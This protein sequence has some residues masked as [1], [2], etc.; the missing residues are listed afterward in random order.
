M[1]SYADEE[2]RA[3]IVCDNGSGM[4][5]AGFAGDDAPRAVFPSI[6]GRPKFEQ[7]M[8]GAGA[9]GPDRVFVGDDCM[10]KR[11]VLATRYPIE[12]GVV[13]NWED[14]E[15]VWAHTFYEQLRADPADHQVLL[16]E[17]PLNPRANREQMARIMFE[18]FGAAAVY[19]Q[20]QAVLSLYSAGRTTGVVLDSGDG[21]THTVPVYEGYSMP[22]ALRRMDLAGRDLT[23]R[24]AHLLRLRGGA[25]AVPSAAREVK[26][27]LCRVA[28][29]FAAAEAAPEEPAAEFE[30]PDGVVMHVGRERYQCPEALFAPGLMGHHDT[31][32]VHALLAATVERC[33]V[34]VRRDL[35][36]NVVLSGG[37]TMYP[38]LAARLQREL[39]ALVPH[40]RIGIVAPPERK[41]SVWIGGSI[42]A[43]LAT[44]QNQWVTKADY[45]ENGPGIVHAKCL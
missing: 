43:S 27:Q 21:V 5:K 16:T 1:P 40:G 41:Y 14:M 15:K 9:G 24:M 37:T 30:L 38:G 33:D 45:D 29:D 4:V 26:E 36:D 20:I 23:E 44:F 31:P 28:L 7:I 32:G 11:G 22:H 3:P 35:Y 19:V 12:H 25:S 18:T 42:L 13:T 2:E 39:E 34:D 10:R 17:A 6:V 8:C